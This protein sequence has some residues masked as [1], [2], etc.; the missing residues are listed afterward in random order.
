MSALA[1]VAL[2]AAFGLLLGFAAIRFRVEG[3]PLADQIES[4]LPQTQCGQCGFAGC[5][6]YAK[7]I[8]EGEADINCC[9]PGGAEVMKSMANLL[10]REVSAG[11]AAAV[12]VKSVAVI[13]ESECIGCALCNR[14][15]PVHAV[16]GAAK[17]MHS[18]LSTE[19]TGCEICYKAC[20]VDCI[21]MR[22]VLPT[23][24]TWVWPH[25]K[26]ALQAAH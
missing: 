20:P 24:D 22:P 17:H 4:M 2:S 12:K 13:K 19:C 7:A 15:C 5:K 6:S 14:S 25:P 10:G 18:V 26:L 1:L 16:V 21:E 8:A 9:P 11:T 23:P 3:N